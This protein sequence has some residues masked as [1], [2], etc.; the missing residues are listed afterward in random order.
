MRTVDDTMMR[1]GQRYAKMSYR[2]APTLFFEFMAPTP[3]VS[4]QA[5]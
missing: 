4:Q 3:A 5:T 2:E 1:G